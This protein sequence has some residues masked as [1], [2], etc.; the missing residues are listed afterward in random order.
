MRK[1]PISGILRTR[2]SSFDPSASGGNKF[3]MRE[4]RQCTCGP[5]A[6]VARLEG[7]KNQRF[8]VVMLQESGATKVVVLRSIRKRS[9]DLNAGWAFVVETLPPHRQRRQLPVVRARNTC[10]LRIRTLMARNTVQSRHTF[11]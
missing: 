3:L 9:T 5:V 10:A 1:P 6:M 8:L 2:R 7:P 11:A 4:R